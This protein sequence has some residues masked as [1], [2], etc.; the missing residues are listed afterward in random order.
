MVEAYVL[1]SEHTERQL[2]SFDA[3]VDAW[4]R[5]WGRF[6][7][8]TMYSNTSDNASINTAAPVRCVPTLKILSIL[9]DIGNLIFNHFVTSCSYTQSSNWQWWQWG[10]VQKWSKTV[11]LEF[12]LETEPIIE[13]RISVNPIDLP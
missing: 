8:I 12:F 13:V 4:E 10:V 7:S 9:N 5:V 1:S 2:W 11:F 3:C 6:S